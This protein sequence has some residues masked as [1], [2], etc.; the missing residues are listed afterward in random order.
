MVDE[1]LHVAP[2]TLTSFDPNIIPIGAR[3][4]IPRSACG[5]DFSGRPAVH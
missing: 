3:C 5:R 4:T 2:K 1:E